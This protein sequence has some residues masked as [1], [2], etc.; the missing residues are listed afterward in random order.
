MNIYMLIKVLPHLTLPRCPLLRW[1][2]AY[3]ILVLIGV[4]IQS[5]PTRRIRHIPYN[6]YSCTLVRTAV[7]IVC[8]VLNVGYGDSPQ[9]MAKNR[10]AFSFMPKIWHQTESNPGSSVGQ[11]PRIR[12]K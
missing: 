9:Q 10:V 1:R 7:V 6:H 3:T 11:L 4:G 12:A 5:R 2:G 8:D